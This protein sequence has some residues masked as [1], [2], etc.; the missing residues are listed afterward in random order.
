MTAFMNE[1]RKNSIDNI[2]ERVKFFVKAIAWLY[3]L[4]LLYHVKKRKE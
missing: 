4:M 2:R 1:E 3:E